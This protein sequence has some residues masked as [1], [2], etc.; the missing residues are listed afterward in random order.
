MANRRPSARQATTNRLSDVHHWALPNGVQ[1]AHRAS[2]ATRLVHVAVILDIGSRDESPRQQGMAHCIEHMLFK[3]TVRRKAFHIL[4]RI[5]SVGGELNAYTTKEKTTYYATV[6]AEHLNR[7]LELLADI[8]FRPTF[9]PHEL[10]KERTVIADEIDAYR[11]DLEEAIYEDFDSH[12]Y[13][14]HPLGHPILGSRETVGGFSSADLRAFHSSALRPGGVIVSITGAASE[15]RVQR[16]IA[17]HFGGHVLQ[18]RAGLR[19]PPPSRVASPL[20]VPRSTSQTHLLL[21]GHAHASNDPR[22]PA[23]NL[24]LHY[25]GGPSMNSRLSLIIRE[26]YGLAYNIQSNY[27]AFTDSGMWG[28]YAATDPRSYTRL[29]HL[30][31]RELARVAE[32]PF[33]Q[34]QL[35]RLQQQFIGSL[36]IAHESLFAQMIA[37]GK[38]YLDFGRTFSLDDIVTAYRALT[39]ADLYAVAQERFAPEAMTQITYLPDA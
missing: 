13:G 37:Q 22:Y 2:T 26:K 12:L 34:A 10:E 20:A 17:Q 24:L 29:Q 6:T 19:V 14:D 35:S 28:I 3:G 38:D 27:Q 5:D 25:L 11:D 30:I 4:S 1:V 16:L 32:Q 39:P 18:G 36:V 9:P 33:S 7:A 21:G 23:F 8:T 31:H 15:A